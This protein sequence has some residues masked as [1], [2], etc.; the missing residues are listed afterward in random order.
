MAGLHLERELED[1]LLGPAV[2]SPSLLTAFSPPAVISGF[3]ISQETSALFH[4]SRREGGISR[5]VNLPGKGS[6]GGERPSSITQTP[7]ASQVSLSGLLPG[8][9]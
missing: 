5:R 9:D 3:L 2:K 4:V 6:E 7:A 8:E 1:E